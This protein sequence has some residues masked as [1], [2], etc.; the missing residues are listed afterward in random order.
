MSINII[1]CDDERAEIDYLSSLVRDWAVARGVDAR[2]FGFES[3]ESFLFAYEADKTADILLLDVQMKEMNGVTLA[4]RLRATNKEIQIIF[5]TGYMEY[6]TDGYDVEALHYLLK[7]ATGEKLAAVLDRAASKL[8][9]NERVLL[10]NRAGESARIPLY[11]VRYI[12]VL[13][14]YV[15]IYADEEYTLKKTLGELEKELDENFFRAGR[16]YIINLRYIR[17]VV[18]TE[19][20]LA[21]G[22]IIPLPRGQYEVLNRALI[23]RL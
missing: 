4:K 8:M 5:V 15:T 9:N 14:N 22:A 6:I 3:A 21:G 2:L 13:R 11:E 7:P 16:S 23:D 1:V 18:K 19:V 12:E 17:K 20:H 10:I